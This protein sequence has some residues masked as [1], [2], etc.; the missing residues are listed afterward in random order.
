MCVVWGLSRIMR[1]F[2]RTGRESST[3]AGLNAHAGYD[4]WLVTPEDKARMVL[5]EL[6]DGWYTPE[7]EDGSSWH[8]TEQTATLSFLNPG[9]PIVLQLDYDTPPELLVG[10]PRTLEITVGERIVRSLTLDTV[11]QQQLRVLLPTATLERHDRVS[12]QLAVDRPFVPANLDAN[13][14]DTRELGIRVFRLTVEHP[15]VRTP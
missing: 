12:V 6:I 11:G 15:T 9:T 2:L 13:S 4:G 1:P 3:A 14:Q 8:W 5:V 7:I 10:S